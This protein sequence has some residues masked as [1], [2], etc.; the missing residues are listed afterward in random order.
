MPRL[1][2]N[3]S[4]LSDVLLLVG[5]AFRCGCIIKL[6]KC[7]NKQ[8][9][10]KQILGR[11]NHSEVRLNKRNAYSC[12]YITFHSFVCRLHIRCCTKCSQPCLQFDANCARTGVRVSG[13]VPLEFCDVLT[14]TMRPPNHL[15]SLTGGLADRLFALV[16]WPVKAAIDYEI[17][18]KKS[19][20][21]TS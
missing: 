18:T 2:Q 14:V 8:K 3:L 1:R 16:G 10:N 5:C 4:T 9:Q 7:R 13:Y 20:T 21:F 12:C 17:F 15:H 19:S 11:F 6:A